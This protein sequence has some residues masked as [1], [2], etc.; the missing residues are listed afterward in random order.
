[1]AE[2]LNQE[3]TSEVFAKMHRYRIRSIDLAEEAGITPAYLSLVLNGRRDIKD[4]DA[5][6]SRIESALDRLVERKQEE[7]E[8]GEDAAETGDAGAD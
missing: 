1:M 5:T 8:D 4:M 2:E 6:R 7:A 3:W